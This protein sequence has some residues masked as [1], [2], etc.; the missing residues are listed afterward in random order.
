MKKRFLAVLAVSCLAIGSLSACQR[1]AAAE[2]E[3]DPS[4]FAGQN[5][6]ENHVQ[7]VQTAGAKEHSEPVRDVAYYMETM[8]DE[9]LDR[10]ELV[11]DSAKAD[12]EGINLVAADS[13]EDCYVYC[14]EPGGGL[15]IR[16]HGKRSILPEKHMDFR[17]LWMPPTLACE[18]YDG[19]GKKEVALELLGGHGTGILVEELLLI[20]EEG[21]RLEIAEFEQEDYLAQLQERLEW[22]WEPEWEQLTCSQDGA[23]SGQVWDLSQMME[24]I[25]TA[26]QEIG[27]DLAREELFEGIEFQEQVCF[28]IGD[29]TLQ[30]VMSGGYRLSCFGSLYYG[31][32]GD[33]YPLLEA[34]VQVQD[35]AF[36][37][38]DLALSGGEAIPDEEAEEKTDGSG[39][40][41]TEEETDGAGNE[42]IEEETGDSRNEVG[43]EGTEGEA[44]KEK[45]HSE[46]VRDVAYYMETMTDEELDRLECVDFQEIHRRWEDKEEKGLILVAEV[47]AHSCYLYYCESDGRVF[48]RFHG[49]RKKLE[50]GLDFWAPPLLLCGDYDKDGEEEAALIWL[51]G[52]GTGVCVDA[53][54]VIK[55]EKEGLQA[56]PLEE[57]DYL[58][59]A[60]KRVSW[61]WDLEEERLS[62]SLDGKPFDGSWDLTELFDG[63]AEGAERIGNHYEREGAFLGISWWEQVTITAEDGTLWLMMSGGYRLKGTGMC[64]YE[65]DSP[66]LRAELLFEDGGFRLGKIEMK[67]GRYELD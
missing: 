26:E 48:I 4:A 61:E 44:A 16:F 42:E 49:K 35:G 62:C 66:E 13:E 19:D 40:G 8:T 46:P 63:L 2:P 64:V 1:P 60:E 52:H 47:P 36:T 10:L 58:E 20:Q 32:S 15:F 6:E 55:E 31:E 27:T 59:P 33:P 7:T 39:N 3:G 24:R 17:L 41:E 57:A 51:F 29:G 50:A 56:F 34:E 21:D 5:K 9:E 45:E 38:G 67:K 54:V 22:S 37:L 53:L 25:W 65:E 12:S 18:D 30:M 28:E 23:S 11:S 43:A 14:C